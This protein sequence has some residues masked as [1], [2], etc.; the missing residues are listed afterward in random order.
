MRKVNILGVSRDSIAII[1]D[2]LMEAFGDICLSVFPNIREEI[3]PYTPVEGIRYEMMPFGS[4]PKP[5]E[6]V[7]FGAASPK[8]KNSIFEYFNNNAG[9]VLDNYLSIIHPTAYIAAS[10][11]MQNGVLVEPHAVV[12]SQSAIGFGVFIKR[13][14]LIGHH[15]V[16]GDF[17]DINP[18]VVVS[19]KVNIGKGC[20]IGSG[21][22][23]KDNVSIGENTLIGVGSVV[24]KDVPDHSIAFGNPCKVVKKNKLWKV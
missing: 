19:G 12:S 3:E 16:I 6:Q 14:A 5:E 4:F 24:T 20:V 2:Q 17:T 13:G 7:F 8:N 15:N 1:F 10:S 22:V 21:T 9:I 11:V 23:I 18:G